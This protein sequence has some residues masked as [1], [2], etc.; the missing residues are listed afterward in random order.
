MISRL[1]PT[2]LRYALHFTLAFSETFK[3]FCHVLPDTAFRPIQQ[4]ESDFRAS[5]HAQEQKPELSPLLYAS[6]GIA[7][8]ERT[9]LSGNQ[10]NLA[11]TLS[12]LLLLVTQNHRII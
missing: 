4:F 8:K 3:I 6:I 9:K 11:T 1:F 10:A 2:L 12:E 5:A 7:G